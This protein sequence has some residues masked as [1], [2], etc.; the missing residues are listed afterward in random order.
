MQRQRSTATSPTSQR[1]C[2][3]SPSPGAVQVDGTV[4]RQIAGLFVAAEHGTQKAQ[5]HTQQRQL[6]CSSGPAAAAAR[7][8]QHNLTPLVGSDDEIAMLAAGARS[9]RSRAA[10]RTRAASSAG[11]DRGRSRFDR[12]IRAQ[13]A[14]R[15]PHASVK[16]KL[17]AGLPRH[18]PLHPIT[19]WAPARFGSCRRPGGRD[20][21]PELEELARAGA[22]DPGGE[23]VSTSAA[24]ATVPC[25]RIA[26]QASRPRNYSACNSP[27]LTRPA[28]L[29]ARRATG[30]RWCSRSKIC[31]RADPTTLDVLHSM[32]ERGRRS[33]LC[34]WSQRRTRGSSHPRASAPHHSAH[35]ARAARSPAGAGDGR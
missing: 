1:E 20:G 16:M 21:F 2:R 22:A 5:E 35:F 30:I 27:R 26:R 14:T 10:S 6:S 12:G 29:M 32:A 25:H 7:S 23:C 18:A 17:F 9:E 31:I 15:C 4:Q 3:R 24:A 19:G 28:D 8:A 11:Q 13:L 33:R 34:S